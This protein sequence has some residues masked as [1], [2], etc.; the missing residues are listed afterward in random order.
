[1]KIGTQ[2]PF[3]P[4]MNIF[5][6]DVPLVARAQASTTFEPIYLIVLQ[7]AP[8]RDFL[9]AEVRYRPKKARIMGG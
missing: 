2:S 1:M 9:N 5:S 8:F 7:H 3:V 4:G 6:K